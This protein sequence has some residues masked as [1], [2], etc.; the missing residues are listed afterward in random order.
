[1]WAPKLELHEALAVECAHFVDCI[2]YKRLPLS[3]GAAGVKVVRLLEA[4]S[5]S[6]AEEGRRVSL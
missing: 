6:L 4:A 3:S 1:M 2:R 5:Q